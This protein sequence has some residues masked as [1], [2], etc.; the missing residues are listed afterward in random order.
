M[1]GRRFWFHPEAAAE[2]DAAA[3]WYDQRRRGLGAEFTQAVLRTVDDVRDAP[4][5]W[6]V[7]RGRSRRALL[8]RFPYAIVYRETAN[9]DIEIVAVAHT[10]RR[11]GYW[12]QR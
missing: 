2:V 4:Q 12:A 11:P 7:V 9:G 6:R 3:S 10:S 5:R 1:A 8:G